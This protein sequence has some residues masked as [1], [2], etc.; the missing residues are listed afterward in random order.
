MLLLDDHVIWPNYHGNS[1]SD[2]DPFAMMLITMVLTWKLG[3]NSIL[4]HCYTNAVHFL[5]ITKFLKIRFTSEM[6]HAGADKSSFKKVQRA[7]EWKTIQVNQLNILCDIVKCSKNIRF[8]CSCAYSLWISH[9]YAQVH[10]LFHSL[11]HTHTHTLFLSFR[12][13][14]TESLF[15]LPLESDR[16]RAYVT[17]LAARIVWVA[18]MLTYR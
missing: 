8:Y 17:I 5:R 9:V 11:T 18:G 7:R 12:I 6:G 10:A 13:K 15:Y 4:Y 1:D 3:T 14:I 2:V 16:W